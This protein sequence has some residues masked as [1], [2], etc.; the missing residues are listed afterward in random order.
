MNQQAIANAHFERKKNT[1]A[2][3]I[4]IGVCLLLFLTFFLLKWHAP[5]V[6][7]PVLSEGIEIN[8]GDGETGSGNVEP[9]MPGTPAPE[10]SN[11][12]NASMPT[13]ATTEPQNIA[14]DDNDPEAV[15]A[16]AKPIKPIHKVTPTP[17][18][19]PPANK[20]TVS[21]TSV[22]AV[23]VV[24]PKALFSMKGG[25][26]NGGNGADSYNQVTN[27]GNNG[28]VGN[29][30]N[31]N[32][33]VTGD[34]YTGY[35]GNGKSGISISKGLKGRKFKALPSFEDDFSEN[36]KVYVNITVD[37]N[38]KVTDA[39]IDLRLTNTANSQIKRIALKKAKELSLSEGNEDLQSGTILFN[40]IVRG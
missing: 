11:Q 19:T 33:T 29:Q 39:Q 28:G 20:A 17:N 10:A 18:T 7:Q 30:G 22:A 31:P 40:F 38:G 8:L 35:N 13:A 1:Q 21:K 16:I 26:G 2:A 34:S 6:T 5:N 9:L 14:T 23:P 32:G 24:K 3:A 37:K 4:T 36:A 25:T 15:A 27:Q 12:E